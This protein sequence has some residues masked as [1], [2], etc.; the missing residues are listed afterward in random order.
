MNGAPGFIRIASCVPRLRVA[1]P[2]W[3]A[4]QILEL[5]AKA[6]E[7]GAAV[8]VFPELS[9]TGYTCGD[10]FGTKSLLDAAGNAL[11]TLAAA[12]AGRRC[13]LVVGTPVRVGA[14]LFDAAAVLA[15]GRAIG[16]PFKSFLP[17]YREF[18]EKR[19]FRPA[20]E[21]DGE[22][23]RFGGFDV[24]AGAS[25]VFRCR[26]DGNGGGEFRFGVEICEDLWSVN[27]PSGAL[28][29]RGAQAIFNLSAG[30]ELVGKAEWRRALVSGQSG[31]ICGIYAYAGAGVHESTADAVFSGH[32]MI[33]FNGGVLAE[34]E[35]FQRSGSIVFADVN[36][37]WCDTLR[38]TATSFLDSDPGVPGR[39]VEA[40]PARRSP[41]LSF[42][43]LDAHPF[44]P[45]D[46]RERAVR[47]REILDIQA[48]GLAK[49][50]EHTGARR[51]LLGVSGGLDSTLAMLVCARATDILELPRS[52]TLAVTMPG[53]GTTARTRGNAEILADAIGAELREIPIG[54]AVERHFSDIGHDPA[55]R[56]VTYENSQARERTQILMDLANQERGFVVGTGDLSEIALGWSTFNGDQMSM[57]N[58]NCGVPKT[59]MRHIVEWAADRAAEEGS[60]A[61]AKVLRDIRDTPVSPELLPGGSQS[62]ENTL[63]RYDLHDFFLYYAVKYGETPAALRDLALAAFGD[64]TTPGET[65][66]ALRTF[67]SRFISQQYKR[68]ASPDGPKVGTVALSPRGDWRCPPDAS[69]SA[70]RP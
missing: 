14:R 10:L 26:D 58:P 7:A 46:T 8:A 13:I 4:E 32:A 3:N 62:T 59:L 60:D 12:T 68:N 33:A 34:N 15:D 9:V 37:T 21:F 50:I 25:L 41:D 18:Y 67:C 49:R 30:T 31:R 24:P 45:R 65:D 42:A 56:D 1:D 2:E 11:A 48:A 53:F 28:A 16:F 20:R 52:F 29:L 69:F 39:I 54:P 40:P 36:P 57:Y 22:T 5:Y 38:A 47:C 44:V 51:L 61:L 66:A 27:P 43:R 64:E 19:H 17:E 63:G 6:E 35:R 55:V 23:V 70:F